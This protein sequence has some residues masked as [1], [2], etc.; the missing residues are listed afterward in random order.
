MLAEPLDGTRGLE[1]C[2]PGFGFKEHDSTQK[3]LLLVSS[4]WN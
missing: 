3:N 2:G 1:H 4:S